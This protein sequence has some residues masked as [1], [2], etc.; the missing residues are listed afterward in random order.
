MSRFTNLFAANT[1]AATGLISAAIA[2]S[3]SASADPAFPPVDPAMPV[4]PA[5][6]MLQQFASNPRRGSSTP[7]N[8]GHGSGEWRVATHRSSGNTAGFADRRR[9]G[10]RAAA[11]CPGTGGNACPVLRNL[12]APL[13]LLNQLGLPGDVANLT[14]HNMPFPIAI[15]DQPGNRTGTDQPGGAVPPA[16]N[17]AITPTTPG[18]AGIGSYCRSRPCPDFA[19]PPRCLTHTQ[20]TGETDRGEDR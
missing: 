10:H 6:N 5:L 16:T 18:G 1:I 13:Q 2:L 20:S 19:S 17:P 8:G 11:R 7:A 14:P 9:T 15:G 12:P 3:P 4:M